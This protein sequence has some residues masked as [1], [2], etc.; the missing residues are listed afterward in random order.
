MSRGT[1]RFLGVA[2][3]LLVSLVSLSGCAMLV[4]KGVESATGVK[5]DQSANK[6]TVTGKNG[7]TATT[8][9]GKLPDGLPSGFPVYAG[10]VKLGNKVQTPTGTAFQIVTETPDDAKT[11]GDWYVTKLKAA[12]WTI[13][14]RNDLNSNGKAITTISAKSGAKMQ[15]MIIVGASA[16]GAGNSVNIT[17]DV[18]P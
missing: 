10:T 3:V 17:L 12:G 5:V 7:A 11:I 8:Q 14:A 2:A 1:M 13:D 15:A 9:E 16:D 4:Q 18:K 6:I